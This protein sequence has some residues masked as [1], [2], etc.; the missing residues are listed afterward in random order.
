[1]GMSVV[2]MVKKPSSLALY[3]TVDQ[4]LTFVT[5]HEKTKHNAVDINLR[6]RP[7]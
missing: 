6:Y 2:L 3:G 1:M 7:K 5:L 4:Y